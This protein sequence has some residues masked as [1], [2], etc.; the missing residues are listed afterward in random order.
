MDTVVVTGGRE[1][2]RQQIVTFVA[3]VTRVEGDVIGRWRDHICPMVVGLTDPQA[4]FVQRRLVDVQNT[5]RKFKEAVNK[6]CAPNLFVIITDEAEQV[7]TSWKSRDPGMF[8][9]KTRDGVS[10][11]N[12]D[13]P[14]RA[15][16]NAIMEPSDGA[17]PSL[18][19]G[20]PPGFKL[21]PSRIESSAA[22]NIRAVVVLVDTRAAGSVTLS[23]I[24]DYIAMVS[25]AQLDLTANLG[26]VNSILRLFAEPRPATPPT[27]LTDWDLAFLNGLYRTSYTPINQRRD[28]AARMA[29]ALAP[30]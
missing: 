14:V 20:Q 27:A 28:I 29:R 9:W 21:K 10:R 30:R 4:Q 15:W 13:G 2:V 26:G 5:V 22:E 16:H 11:S 23:Q 8:R 12:G 25:L 7:L 17:P 1:A 19:D 6:T 3:S 24:A 18:N